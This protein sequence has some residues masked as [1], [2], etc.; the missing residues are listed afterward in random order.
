MGSALNLWLN[1]LGGKMGFYI[2]KSISAG[3]FRFNLSG[4]GIGMSVGVKGFR[5]GTGPRGNYVHMGRGGLYYRA[6]LNGPRP[7][8]AGRSSTP[9][10]TVTRPPSGPGYGPTV[11]VETGDVAEMR[12]A[13]G[14]DIIADINEKN[15]AVRSMPF[16]LGAGGLLSLMILGQPGAQSLG[17]VALVLTG[18]VTVISARWDQGRKTSVIMYDLDEHSLAVF[19]QFAEEFEK[20]ARASHIWNIDTA[21]ATSDLKRNAGAS[22]LLSRVRASFTYSVPPVVKTNISVPAML[23]GKNKLFFFPDVV[24]IADGK[25]IGA[26]SYD[27]ISIYWNTTVFI[28]EERVPRDSDVVGETWRFVNKDGGPD[29]RFNNNRRIPKVLY[30]QLGLRGPSGFQKVLHLSK[31][32]DR[33]SF[34]KAFDA[35][36]G[37]VSGLKQRALA[38]PNSPAT[39]HPST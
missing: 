17:F 13:N 1:G 19:K 20:A 6:S 7:R 2:R 4:S 14:S 24:L 39:P 11:Q 28:E 9:T 36:T 35:L 22:S 18:I 29:R 21:Q 30:Q 10:A 26:A 31:V 37:L 25:A 15:R 16:V 32:E 12:P 5:V 38:A 23:G 34:D 8:R 27:Q 3:P 33:S